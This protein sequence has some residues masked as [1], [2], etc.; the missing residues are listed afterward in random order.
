MHEEDEPD[1]RLVPKL[2]YNST[3]HTLQLSI[4]HLKV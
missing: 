2:A 4:I 1:M 3:L